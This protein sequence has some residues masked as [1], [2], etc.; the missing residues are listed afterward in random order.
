MSTLLSYDEQL[1]G[2]AW[3]DVG[4]L[5]ETWFDPEVELGVSVPGFATAT[6]TIQGTASAAVKVVPMVGGTVQSRGTMG[7]VLEVNESD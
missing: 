3:F 7:A 2:K 4:L 5:I 1:K 6:V